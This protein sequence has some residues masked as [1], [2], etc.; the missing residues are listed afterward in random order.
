MMTAV[1]IMVQYEKFNEQKLFQEGNKVVAIVKI[2]K[3][4]YSNFMSTFKTS[5]FFLTR[6]KLQS[7]TCVGDVLGPIH[8]SRQL[9]IFFE[10]FQPKW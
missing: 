10:T 8:F 7:C 1:R 2:S 6:I 9:G 3:T 4:V 5:E